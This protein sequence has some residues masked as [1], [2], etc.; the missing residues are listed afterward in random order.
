[1]VISAD[2]APTVAEPNAD[3]R[4]GSGSERRTCWVIRRGLLASAVGLALAP[5]VGAS[6]PPRSGDHTVSPADTGEPAFDETYR[7]RRIQGTLLRAD[8]C[9]DDCAWQVTV[10]GHPLH[11]MRRADGTWLTMV[12]HYSSYRTS[13]AATRAAVDE[14]GPGQR[15]RDLEPGP[16][17]EGY[18]HMGEQHGVRA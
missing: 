9:G 13:L 6:R 15:L 7:G 16:L 8:G 12:D 3:G 11:L 1:M 2:G 18:A 5:L 17:G 14:L 4:A 10:D